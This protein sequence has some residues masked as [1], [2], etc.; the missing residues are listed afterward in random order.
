MV[1]VENVYDEIGILVCRQGDIINETLISDL[2]NSN[3]KNVTILEIYPDEE[4][5]MTVETDPNQMAKDLES[6]DAALDRSFSPVMHHEEIQ[7][8]AAVIKKINRQRYG[9]LN[10]T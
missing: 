10:Q 4:K 5:K 9:K 8:I 1:V 7:Q 6:F 3:I 2:R